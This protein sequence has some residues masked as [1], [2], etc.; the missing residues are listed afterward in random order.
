MKYRKTLDKEVQWQIGEA[1]YEEFLDYI[2]EKYD[3]EKSVRTPA[4]NKL[5]DFF[6]AKTKADLVTMM[7]REFLS[8]SSHEISELKKENAEL[9]LK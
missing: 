2:D 9:K 4:T 1:H 3:I 8:N 5:E 6:K 7:M